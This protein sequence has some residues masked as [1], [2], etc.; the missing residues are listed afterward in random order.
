AFVDYDRPRIIVD[1]R[2][3][4]E[5]N[6]QWILMPL[7]GDGESVTFDP[8]KKLLIY[9][10]PEKG[11]MY[12]IGVDPGTGVGGDR[13]VICVTRTG[14][15]AIPDVQVAEFA[16]DDIS[17]VEV[18]AWVA[19]ITAYYG[20]FM[21]EGQQPKIVIEQRRKYGDSCYH[22]LKLHG[23]RNHH[24]WREFDKKSLKPRQ[25]EQSREGWFTNAWSRP[26]LLNYFKFAIEGGWFI[27][28]SKGLIEEL[29]GQE[30]KFT[31]EGKSRMD[32]QSG[33]H[34]DRIFA[35]A[36]SYFS[37]HSMDVMAE[38]AKVRYNAPAEGE[39]WMV[40]LSPWRGNVVVNSGAEEFFAELGR[41]G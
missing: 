12:S 5:I 2:T 29:E 36:M 37:L 18:Y 10:H 21:E 16:S 24:Q 4:R 41:Q 23:F 11:A 26:M 22:A 39:G 8:L 15:D 33:K 27:P 13:T 6:L 9:V 40:D 35:A 20:M 7:V 31:T 28:N 30:Q 3:P 34:D 38:R 19:A 14:H 25:T 32:H 1:W 17:N